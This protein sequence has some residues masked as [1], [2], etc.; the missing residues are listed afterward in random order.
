MNETGAEKLLGRGDM[1]F[2]TPGLS[3]PLRIHGAPCGF[4]RD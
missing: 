4:R 1:L 2:V 3:H